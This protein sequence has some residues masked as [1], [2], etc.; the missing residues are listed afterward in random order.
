MEELGG[1][2][3]LLGGRRECIPVVGEGGGR[4]VQ[5]GPRFGGRLLMRRGIG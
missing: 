2:R 5:M 1:V 4:E 3:E